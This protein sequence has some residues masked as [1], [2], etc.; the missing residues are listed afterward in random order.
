MKSLKT[1]YNA[2]ENDNNGKKFF[3]RGTQ[4]TDLNHYKSQSTTLDI[5]LDYTFRQKR[6]IKYKEKNKQKLTNYGYELEQTV[7]LNLDILLSFIS[8]TKYNNKKIIITNDNKSR[9][10]AASSSFISTSSLIQ[11]IKT[12]IE[13]SKKKSGI[14]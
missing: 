14:K 7:S 4:T 11:L 2:E 9:D 12:I 6:N 13:K 8:N 1:E 3:Y 10:T 5:F